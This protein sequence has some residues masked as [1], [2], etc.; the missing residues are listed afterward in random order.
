MEV[1]R[2]LLQVHKKVKLYID[3]CYI[4]RIVF[5][6]TRSDEINYITIYNIKKTKGEIIKTLLKIK[7]IHSSRQFIITDVY[8]DNEFDSEDINVAMLRS[9]MH[10]CAANEHGP[11]I[12][13]PIRTAKKKVAPYVIPF[14][15]TDIPD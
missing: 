3:L 12:K 10:I 2:E 14:H 15:T 13:R 9:V 8:A 6:I 11:K 5:L 7:I 4:N 1:P